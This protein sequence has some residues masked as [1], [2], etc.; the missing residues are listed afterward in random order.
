[1]CTYAIRSFVPK[2]LKTG[3]RA[4]CVMKKPFV[5][6]AVRTL[7]AREAESGKKAVEILVRRITEHNQP[8]NSYLIPSLL[9]IRQS[10]SSFDSMI[11]SRI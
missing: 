5:L 10:T 1:M 6:L 8:T 9:V 2:W 11:R 4:V 3:T 7:D